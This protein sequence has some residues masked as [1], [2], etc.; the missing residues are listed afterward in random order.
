[1]PSLLKLAAIAGTYL[2]SLALLTSTL[3]VH[4]A[5]QERHSLNDATKPV[6]Q[7]IV[8]GGQTTSLIFRFNSETGDSWI[9][10]NKVWQKIADKQTLPASDYDVQVDRVGGDAFVACRSEQLNSFSKSSDC[11]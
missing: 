9:A 2:I 8:S 10:K 5:A 1:M 3:H 11:D 7:I 4:A 6:Y